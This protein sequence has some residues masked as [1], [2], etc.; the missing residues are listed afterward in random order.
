MF[1]FIPLSIVRRYLKLTLIHS[2]L[3]QWHFHHTSRLLHRITHSRVTSSALHS[4]STYPQD[5]KSHVFS[6]YIPP[7]PPLL[8]RP[9]HFYTPFNTTNTPQF[10]AHSTI[11]LKPIPQHVFI[12]PLHFV[13]RNPITMT[14][15]AMQ[16][17][18]DPYP[19]RLHKLRKMLLF[20]RWQPTLP[21]PF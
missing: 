4:H 3:I 6:S 13:P 7:P 9:N 11:L 1:C 18:P 14:F 21:S 2:Q 12:I 19:L 5:S 15:L 16:S 8:A 20:P 10:N 17:Q